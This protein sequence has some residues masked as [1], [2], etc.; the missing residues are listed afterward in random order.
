MKF[1]LDPA[2]TRTNKKY[3]SQAADGPCVELR[4]NGGNQASNHQDISR[5]ECT[6]YKFNQE[7]GG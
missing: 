7:W 1:A 4:Q 3:L 6:T 2:L 5:C